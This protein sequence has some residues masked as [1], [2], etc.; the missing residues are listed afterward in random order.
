VEGQRKIAELIAA[1]QPEKAKQ[2]MLIFRDQMHQLLLKHEKLA[3]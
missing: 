1:K 3:K 2:Q